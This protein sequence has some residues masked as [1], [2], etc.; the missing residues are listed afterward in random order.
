M[1]N[2]RLPVCN[3]GFLMIA[4]VGVLFIGGKM[5][6]NNREEPVLGKT[7]PFGANVT[8]QSSQ[9]GPRQ[10]AVELSAVDSSDDGRLYIYVMHD[11]DPRTF[12]A[13][14]SGEDHFSSFFT[15]REWAALF[16][17]SLRCPHPVSGDTP[18]SYGAKF[19]AALPDYPMLGR[20]SDMY[21]YVCYKPD[22]VGYLREECLQ[23]QRSSSTQKA[24]EGLG[25][26]VQGCDEALRKGSGLLFVPD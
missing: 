24:Q 19:S 5:V 7:G 4:V 10:L 6:T 9:E 22:E 26:I 13:G 16:L 12:P 2:V 21:I 23:A 8:A 11:P 18:E 17:D 3:R 25:K 15:G 14:L 1:N 20:I